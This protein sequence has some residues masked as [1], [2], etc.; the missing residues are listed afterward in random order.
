MKLPMS[1]IIRIPEQLQD[2]ERMFVS[3]YHVVV[4][5]D[6]D[7]H[8]YRYAESRSTHSSSVF[9]LALLYKDSSGYCLKI[10]KDTTL[11]LEPILYD[12]YI[13]VKFMGY[14]EPNDWIGL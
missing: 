4:D 13:S 10:H 6:G 8:V 12:V 7:T 2:N 14:I 1:N 3:N 5:K 11:K 9:S